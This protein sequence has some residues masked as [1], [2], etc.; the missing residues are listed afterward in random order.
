[1]TTLSSNEFGPAVLSADNAGKITNRYV[2]E[3]HVPSRGI[4][5][6]LGIGEH[7]PLAR[8]KLGPAASPPH[9]QGG[10]DRYG[11]GVAG[12]IP[13]FCRVTAPEIN[14][15]PRPNSL[16][17]ARYRSRACRWT[18]VPKE[19]STWPGA[20]S[21]VRAAV[22]G[23]AHRLGALPGRLDALRRPEADRLPPVLVLIVLNTILHRPGR[24]TPAWPSARVTACPWPTVARS[25]GQGRCRAILLAL[26]SPAV[27][28]D[29]DR[30][31]PPRPRGQLGGD[32]RSPNAGVLAEGALARPLFRGM[33]P[34]GICGRAI[35]R[36]EPFSRASR[37]CR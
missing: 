3:F 22:R 20:A 6:L 18:R 21:A 19:P 12:R 15:N 5:E 17:R 7:H 36:R 25:A 11:H 37:P 27:I 32:P 26:L 14:P 10:R 28:M 35:S 8:T 33:A 16:V 31:G 24:K 9:G 4:A 34:L 29:A 30:R 2:D 13:I 23:A 1:V